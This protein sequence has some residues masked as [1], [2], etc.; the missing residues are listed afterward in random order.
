MALVVFFPVVS[1]VSHSQ[2]SRNWSLECSGIE[3]KETSFLSDLDP[4]G[5]CLRI[6]EDHQR[7]RVRIMT[8]SFTA[9]R[10][11][12]EYYTVLQL[13]EAWKKTFLAFLTSRG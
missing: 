10:R 13:S 6:Y 8:D 9:R 1:G 11:V 3:R 2:A 7:G 5:A 12:L 4:S